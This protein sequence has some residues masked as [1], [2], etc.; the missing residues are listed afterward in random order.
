MYPLSTPSHFIEDIKAF[1]PEQKAAVRKFMN[2]QG[3]ARSAAAQELAKLASGMDQRQISALTG[4]LGIA[5]GS[6]EQVRKSAAVGLQ[7][8]GIQNSA[9]YY[10]IK[11]FSEVWERSANL[12]VRLA[13][14]EKIEIDEINFTREVLA[15]GFHYLSTDRNNRNDPLDPESIHYQ[16][17]EAAKLLGH[18]GAPKESAAIVERI[19]NTA[20]VGNN[21][22]FGLSSTEKDA[23]AAKRMLEILSSP[24]PSF[25]RSGFAGIKDMT[26]EA[27]NS[28]GEPGEPHEKYAIQRG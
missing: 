28:I 24:M 26:P 12:D 6:Y 3:E 20:P 1:K 14:G 25:I 8:L 13:L 2:T 10:R 5:M 22:Y 11:N 15:N 16:F 18:P 21:P 4:G 27:R 23:L 9:D 7:H 17:A 19:S